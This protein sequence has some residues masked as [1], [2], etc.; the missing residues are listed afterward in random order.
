MARSGAGDGET[1]VVLGMPAML[2]LYPRALTLPG[3]PPLGPTL[4]HLLYKHRESLD[5]KNLQ[6]VILFRD[7]YPEY[8]SSALYPEVPASIHL[9][10]RLIDVPHHGVIDEDVEMPDA[11]GMKMKRSVQV[12]GSDDTSVIREH[13]VV[14]TL[15]H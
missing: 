9:P 2:R 14:V 13:G 12:R 3:A 4:A 10:F 15:N 7:N 1:E 6:S 11:G 8:D 5:I